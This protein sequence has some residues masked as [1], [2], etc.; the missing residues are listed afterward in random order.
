MN[1]WA[2]EY[3]KFRIHRRLSMC[4][5]GMSWLWSL[6]V[7]MSVEHP[8]S[9]VV[10][11]VEHPHNENTQELTSWSSSL[12]G[13]RSVW[14]G[15]SEKWPYWAFR[16]NLKG[17]GLHMGDIWL[18]AGAEGVYRPTSSFSGRCWLFCA[19]LL[20]YGIAGLRGVGHHGRGIHSLIWPHCRYR[21]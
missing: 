7:V 8:R 20:R 5:I 19:L 17:C 2:Y 1:S 16:T 13:P 3:K 6:E 18:S 9:E 21:Q 11:S 15:L 14:S 12:D 10:M 4:F